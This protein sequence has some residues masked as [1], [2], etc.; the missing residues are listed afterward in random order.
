MELEANVEINEGYN[1]WGIHKTIILEGDQAVTKLTYDAAPMLEAAKAERNATA[2]ERWGEMRKVGSIPMS[3]VSR[4]MRQDGG[5]DTKR[6]L[7]WLKQN[8]AFV[9]FDR[10]LK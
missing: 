7:D 8:P 6:C 3:V 10:V 2:G 9:T 1:P 4:F 5:F